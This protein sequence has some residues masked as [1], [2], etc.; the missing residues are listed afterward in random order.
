VI[1]REDKGGSGKVRL[2]LRSFRKLRQSCRGGSSKDPE[3]K[4]HQPHGG[5]QPPVMRSAFMYNN[6]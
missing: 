4:S 5:S 2:T 1:R 6:K 3:F